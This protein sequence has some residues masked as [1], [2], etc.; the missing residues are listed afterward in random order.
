M[1]AYYYYICAEKAFRAC[2]IF[3]LA[4]IALSLVAVVA[5]PI[6]YFS[7]ILGALS[8]ICFALAVMSANLMRRFNKAASHERSRDVA[9]QNPNRIFL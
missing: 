1:L 5:V 8:I 9:H 3:T 4:A 2:V 6:S 7:L